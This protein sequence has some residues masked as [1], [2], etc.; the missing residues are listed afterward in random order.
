M[1]AN[2]LSYYAFVLLFLCAG[3]WACSKKGAAPQEPLAVAKQPNFEYPGGFV[4]VYTPEKYKGEKGLQEMRDVMGKPASMELTM[5]DYKYSKKEEQLPDN[6]QA[7][8]QELRAFF[9]RNVQS[10]LEQC[11]YYQLGGHKILRKALLK[12]DASRELS[13]AIAY[14]LL[15]LDKVGSEDGLLAHACLQKLQGYWS[16][17]KIAEVSRSFISRIEQN[18]ALRE[19]EIEEKGFAKASKNNIERYS[20]RPAVQGLLS[21][22]QPRYEAYYEEFMEKHQLGL[23]SLKALL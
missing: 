9:E 2:Q 7:Y 11:L 16:K 5:I 23:Q 20:D 17:E 19:Q 3:T 18:Y 21:S 15:L 6:W 10:E 14:Y 8:H 4:K 22:M 12:A 13:E 1:K